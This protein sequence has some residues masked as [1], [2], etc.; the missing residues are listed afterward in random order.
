MYGNCLTI[1]MAIAGHLNGDC[2]TCEYCQ[3]KSLYSKYWN[4]NLSSLVYIQKVLLR[5]QTTHLTNWKKEPP[6]ANPPVRL[7][8][9]W[10]KAPA[11]REWWKLAAPRFHWKGQTEIG[12]PERSSSQLCILI[13]WFGWSGSQ[14]SLWSE[15]SWKFQIS[16]FLTSPKTFT[17]NPS[18]IIPNSSHNKHGKFWIHSS[19]IGPLDP[20]ALWLAVA[21]LRS[22]RHE[23]QHPPRGAGA[24]IVALFLQPQW[25]H[26]CLAWRNGVKIMLEM[27]SSMQWKW[28]HVLI[29]MM[30]RRSAQFVLR[31]LVGEGCRY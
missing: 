8:S 3:E 5:S 22:Q 4:Q 14:S 18:K 9:P 20:K 2:W 28:V 19:I 29:C 16:G 1:W 21:V 15:M 11:T 26:S 13:S 31:L 6:S 27:F 17:D 24:N 12:K 7:A 23:M 30:M 10:V 25:G